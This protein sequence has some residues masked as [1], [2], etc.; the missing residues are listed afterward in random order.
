LEVVQV[1]ASLGAEM[2]IPMNDGET[3]DCVGW[4]EEHSDVV[5]TQAP[6]E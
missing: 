1:L 2:D 5:R 6:S 4:Q 3:P